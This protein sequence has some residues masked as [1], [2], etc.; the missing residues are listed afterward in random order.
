V[1][2]SSVEEAAGVL[3][4]GGVVAF[5][6]AGISAESGIPTFRDPGGMWDRFDPSEFGTWDGL[7]ALAM[8]RPDALASFLVELRRMFA[9]AAP[10]AAHTA[11]AH[12]EAGGILD[13]V[14]TQNVDGLHQAAGSRRVVELHGSFSRTVSPATSCWRTSTGRWW[15]SGPRSCRAWRPCSR[16]AGGARARSDRTS[17]PSA[18]LCRTF[19]R[20]RT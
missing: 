3:A 1:R 10:G 6:G 14:V 2:T 15:G 17:W 16:D 4:G 20:P 7:M 8:T 19:P 11:L 12:L 5:T 18:T 13:A 9:A